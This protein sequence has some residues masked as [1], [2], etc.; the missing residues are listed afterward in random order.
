MVPHLTAAVQ[1]VPPDNFPELIGAL[2]VAI[3][4]WVWGRRSK[5]AG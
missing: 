5:P 2:V 1:A 4:T 3:L